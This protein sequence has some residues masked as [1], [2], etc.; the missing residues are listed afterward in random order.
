MK[1]WNLNEYVGLSVMRFLEKDDDNR[2]GRYELLLEYA[3]KLE[4]DILHKREI[5]QD[6]HREIQKLNKALQRSFYNKTMLKQRF[7]DYI[8]ITRWIKQ[9]L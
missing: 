4:T 6:K 8:T 7:K 9:V 5:I 3:K 2:T 1:L